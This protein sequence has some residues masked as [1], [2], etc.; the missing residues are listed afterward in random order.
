MK[1]SNEGG[2]SRKDLI[3]VELKEARAL[4]DRQ[5]EEHEHSKSMLL[6]ASR[7]GQ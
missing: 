4:L 6:Q 2:N 3:S 1:V 5:A 7:M